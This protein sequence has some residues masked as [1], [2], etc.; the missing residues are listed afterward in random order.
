MRDTGLRLT[1]NSSASRRH[2]L[3]A[4]FNP[5]IRLMRRMLSTLSDEKQRNPEIFSD[6]SMSRARCGPLQET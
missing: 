4:L 3:P 6:E 1:S 5:T 2:V